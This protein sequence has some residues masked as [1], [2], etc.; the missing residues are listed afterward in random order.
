MSRIQASK[1]CRKRNTRRWG[2]I[3]AVA[4][5]RIEKLLKQA[6]VE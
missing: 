4:L 1:R 2:R 6:G 3:G 5:A